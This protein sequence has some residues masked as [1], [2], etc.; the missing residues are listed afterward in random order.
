MRFYNF[1]VKKTEKD[2]NNARM[3]LIGY[4][5]SVGAVS[6]YEYGT[7]KV[8]GISDIDC[9]VIT[10]HPIK[11][12]VIPDEFLFAFEGGTKFAIMKPE[13]FKKVK[14]LGDVELK[15]LWGED[16]EVD[17]APD[18]TLLDIAQV[19]DWLPE[20]ILRLKRIINSEEVDIL[21]ALGFL[22][23]FQYSFDTAR[24]LSDTKL[25]LTWGIRLDSLRSGW[26][27]LDEKE[28]INNTM[29]LVDE[30]VEIGY[31]MLDKFCECIQKEDFFGYLLEDAM[32]LMADRMMLCSSMTQFTIEGL[33]RWG[34]L[35]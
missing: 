30:G 32:K 4:C 5:D 24:G 11:I 31:M 1:P 13:H 17:E 12:P 21:D 7:T 35:V 15:R 6:L 9:I 14:L 16:L 25:G 2:Y 20:R 8:L 23:S 27:G 19:M 33:Y 28:R 3:W 18:K 22:K 29:N 10:E 26:F 34:H